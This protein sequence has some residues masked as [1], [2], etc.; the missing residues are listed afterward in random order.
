MIW[1]YGRSADCH[2]ALDLA[3]IE[4]TS[5]ISALM[6]ISVTIIC[7]SASLLQAMPQQEAIEKSI[8]AVHAGKE[9]VHQMIALISFTS[10]SEE[11]I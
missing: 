11:K 9:L 10:I 6:F 1:I 8:Y 2:P 7:F 3:I 4:R 5:K